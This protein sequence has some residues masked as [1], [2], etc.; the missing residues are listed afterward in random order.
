MIALKGWTYGTEHELGDWSLD[1]K[2][3]KGCTRATDDYT[4][5]NS[6]GVGNDPKG[7]DYRF[8]GEINTPPTD[9]PGGQVEILA[10][11]IRTHPEA[12]VNYRSNL[13][14]HIRVPGLK[15]DLSALKQLA[16][17][18]ADYLEGILEV[19]EPIPEPVKSLFEN[20][21]EFQGA[22]RRWRRRR[23]SHHTV[24]P[25]KR[26][27]LQLVTTSPQKFFEAEV[28]QSKRGK[29]LWHAQPRQAVNVRQL[30]QT[31]TIEFRHFPGTLS[32]NQLAE[33]FRWCRLY[34]THAL[35]DGMDPFS[36]YETGGDWN[37]PRFPEYLHWQEVR[38]RATCHDGTLD[39]EV[40]RD[41]IAR[42]EA[43]VFDTHEEKPR[44]LPL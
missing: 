27:D 3:P 9:T 13:H 22:R 30:L 40:I 11:I 21:E 26:L 41:N 35:T 14:C 29:A 24:L 1:N 20:E 8:G 32:L 12:I 25:A 37:L 33:A 19:I 38:Y 31:D 6:N 7:K 28:P 18:N 44:S 34:L 17:Y 2:L 36:I 43:G 5:V 23:V 39:R 16:Q 15:D 10:E 42:I 4:M